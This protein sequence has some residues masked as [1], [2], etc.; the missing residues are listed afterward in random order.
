MFRIFNLR[1]RINDVTREK[2]NGVHRVVVVEAIEKAGILLVLRCIGAR[3]GSHGR[4]D[5][6]RCAYEVPRGKLDEGSRVVE[7]IIGV[8][9]KRKELFGELLANA[10]V[11][12]GADEEVGD[13]GLDGTCV[14]DVLVFENTLARGYWRAVSKFPIEGLV[15]LVVVAGG[16]VVGVEAVPGFCLPLARG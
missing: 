13:L 3:P 16:G 6:I 4:V 7:A 8:E 15:S 11:A 10:A 9:D 14:G 1:Q 12:D 5:D 2:P